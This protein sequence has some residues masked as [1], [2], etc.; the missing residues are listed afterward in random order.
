MSSPKVIKGIRNKIPS[1]VQEAVKIL[2]AEGST[3]YVV[4]GAVRDL[5]V[6]KEVKDFDLACDLAPPEVSK[7]FRSHGWLTSETGNTFLVSRVIK[8]EAD[9]TIKFSGNRPEKEIE[10]A[11]F[12][13]DI[14]NEI[15][16]TEVE[17]GTIQD[18]AERRDLTINALYID[19]LNGE[20]LDPT[21]HG[22]KDIQKGVVKFV[23]N[24]EKRIQEDLSR[25]FRFFK[26]VKKLGFEPDK[27]SLNA[28]K[29]NFHLLK[30]KIGPSQIAEQLEAI[31]G[32]HDVLEGIPDE[33]YNKYP[34]KVKLKAKGDTL[35]ER[36]EYVKRHPEVLLKF[37]EELKILKDKGFIPDKKDLSF[38]RDRLNYLGNVDEDLPNQ[39]LTKMIHLISSIYD[40]KH[41]FK[42]IA[43]VN[44]AKLDYTDAATLK[45]LLEYESTEILEN[46]AKT[47]T[48]PLGLK[49]LQE[50][51]EEFE[52][53][54]VEVALAEN[55]HCSLETLLILDGLDRYYLE[56]VKLNPVYKNCSAE[57]LIPFVPSKNIV[58]RKGVAYHPKCPP[59]ILDKR[60][61]KDP[62]SRVREAAALNPNCPEHRL[63]ALSHESSPW[64]V[65]NVLRNKN[66]PVPVLEKYSVGD[67]LYKGL[68]AK[69]PNCPIYLLEHPL[70]DDSDV[71]VLENVALNK[72]C[73]DYI[74]DKISLHSYVP[75]QKAIASHKNCP[76]HVLDEYSKHSDQ[77]LKLSVALNPNC[78]FDTAFRLVKDKN[79][80]I[81]RA[82]ADNKKVFNNPE[83]L[84][85]LKERK[86]TELKEYKK[87]K[88]PKKLKS[89]K[90][91]HKSINA[92]LELLLA[93]H[94]YLTKEN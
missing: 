14:H 2:A 22:I 85:Y 38:V 54:S 72:R 5:L 51:A 18:D 59:A 33:E 23:G 62:S 34:K 40:I 60:L 82:A 17:L 88:I 47:V 10:I 66:C 94:K 39:Y 64:I 93:L 15:N 31:I 19:P 20:I 13:K 74:L 1:Y 35:K 49:V 28:I 25:I 77:Q 63:I 55:P 16:K 71:D 11:R 32:L 76:P 26:F 83:V 36:D 9:G 81:S 68:V 27:E 65:M 29:K 80:T 46:L 3:A 50:I 7:I 92:D 70:S 57:D 78:D 41:M 58:L 24:P 61:G 52:Y 69:N 84:A 6:G 12:R 37:Y 44:P 21:G 73:P 90:T 30:D 42:K 91:V 89:P 79:E 45:D 86:G 75:L 53:E 48:E 87:T 8:P 43:Q 4:G 56:H 67:K